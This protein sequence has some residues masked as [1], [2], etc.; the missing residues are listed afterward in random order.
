MLKLKKLRFGNVGRFVTPQE[1]DFSEKKQ[2]IQVNGLFV[3]TGG[4]SGAGK[5]TLI[6][7]MD[8]VLGINKSSATVLQSRYTKDLMWAEGEYEN[9]DSTFKIARIKDKGVT[10]SWSGAEGEGEISGNV[11]LAEEKIIQM[12]GIEP[13]LFRRMT[14]KAQKEDGFFLS[15]T[16][17]ESF[18]FL[19]K[20]IGM[21]EML[22]K[23]EKVEALASEKEKLVNQFQTELASLGVQVQ[24]QSEIVKQSELVIIPQKP[25]PETILI[26]KNEL[27]LYEEK[28][29]NIT[30]EFDSKIAELRLKEPSMS[31]TRPV[32]PRLAEIDYEIT[33]LN[34]EIK[35]LEA[36][37]NDKIFKIQK[38][39]EG[40]KTK[41]SSAEYAG[42]KIKE[43][44]TFIS[45]NNVQL[46]HLM[47]NN[48]P[49]CLQKWLGLALKEKIDSIRNE[50]ENAKAQQ[51][52]LI[53]EYSG[54]SSIIE[55]V[56]RAQTI[57]TVTINTNPGLDINTKVS[58]LQIEKQNINTASRAA[59]SETLKEYSLANKVHLDYLNSLKVD[60]DKERA[61]ITSNINAVKNTVQSL[62]LAEANYNTS[63][64]S[65]EKNILLNQEYLDKYT[66]QLEEKNI[67]YQKAQSEF[68]LNQEAKRLLKSYTN[69]TF[70]EA[71]ETIGRNATDRLNKIPNMSTASIYFEPF[72]EVKGKIKEEISV[73]VSMDG[74]IGIPIKSLSGGERSAADL[75]VDLAVADF[76]EEHS[77][78]GANYLTLDEP[79]GGMDALGKA[80]Y[81]EMLQTMTTNKQILIVDH[82]TE[83]KEMVNDVIM[84]RREGLYSN[85]IN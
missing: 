6:E 75:A 49:T 2:L 30:K 15:L 81:I 78:I 41:K 12:L 16:P 80:S 7:M 34:L 14:H 65:K 43:I 68:L 83:I 33:K 52:S 61:N 59:D 45:S 72:K 24:N 69:K 1:I 5:S 79:L 20:V 77:G 11:A 55:Q 82:S 67:E 22:K 19:I 21:E 4:S 37:K 28:L 18:N 51:D 63:L 85:V 54:L 53:T 70:E 71:L 23:I 62:E 44:S 40:L 50:I 38:A 32:S 66:K 35:N 84:V 9:G 58:L 64:K 27:A 73:V 10:V 31:G 25:N 26:G 8:Y 3:D 46:E 17:K 48:C 42:R 36:E 60:Y 57:L 56:D 13:E 39:L 74:D 29:D 76:I 47:E